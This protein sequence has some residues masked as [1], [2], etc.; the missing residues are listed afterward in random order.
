MC[1]QGTAVLL[2]ARYGGADVDQYLHKDIDTRSRLLAD[3]RAYELRTLIR[4]LHAPCAIGRTQEKDPRYA[5]P[6]YKDHYYKLKLNFSDNNTTGMT[7]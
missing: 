6:T 1:A 4:F 2:A 3:V 5:A 7:T